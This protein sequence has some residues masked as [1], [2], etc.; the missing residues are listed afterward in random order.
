MFIA[1]SHEAI[2]GIKIGLGLSQAT[3]DLRRCKFHLKYRANIELD[4]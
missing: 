1:G 3:D 2:E 4:V